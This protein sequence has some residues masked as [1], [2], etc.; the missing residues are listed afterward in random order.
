VTLDALEANIKSR[1]FIIVPGSM[2]TICVLTLQNGFNVTGESA[3]ADPTMF[4]KE[5]GERISE[6]NAK[7]KIWPL[8]GYALKQE[9]YLAGEGTTFQDRVRMEMRDLADKLA[10]LQAFIN[11]AEQFQRLSVEEQGLLIEQLS[12]MDAYARVLDKRIARF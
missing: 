1:Q 2:L 5:I 11:G 12:C 8:M 10:K 9:L 6:D 7:K 4:N 3:C